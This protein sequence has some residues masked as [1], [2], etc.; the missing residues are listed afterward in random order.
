[1]TDMQSQGDVSFVRQEVLKAAPPPM[2]VH[3]VWPW[4]RANLFGSIGDTILTL[5]GAAVA[6][7]IIV[8]AL[9]W[10]VFNATWLGQTRDTCAANTAGACWAF[11]EANFGQ[12]IYGR[13]PD[14]ERW[15]APRPTRSMSARR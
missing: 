6:L 5:V 1:M 4:M 11:V 9:Q 10:A 7:A 14:P 12:F 8:P 3:G 15:R 13:Y 2:R